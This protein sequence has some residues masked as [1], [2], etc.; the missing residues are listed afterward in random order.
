MPSVPRMSVL[1]R[2]EALELYLEGKTLAQIASKV[3]VSESSVYTCS[4]REKWDEKRKQ[5][6]ENVQNKTI[7]NLEKKILSITEIVPKY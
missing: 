3:G 4:K 2:R 7:K 6:H 5:L 1:Q